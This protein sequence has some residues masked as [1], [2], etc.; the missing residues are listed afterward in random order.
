MD[1][2]P[3]FAMWI[4]GLRSGTMNV[5]VSVGQ[6]GATQPA[7]GL[8]VTSTVLLTDVWPATVSAMHLYVQTSPGSRNASPLSGFWLTRCGSTPLQRPSVTTMSCSLGLPAGTLTAR[9]NST[10]LLASSLA[11]PVLST[12]MSEGGVTTMSSFASLQALL[13]ATFLVSAGR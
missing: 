11:G 2:G 7:S 1:A 13:V 12:W 10:G 3:D 8:P 4:A 5:S 9:V 6:F